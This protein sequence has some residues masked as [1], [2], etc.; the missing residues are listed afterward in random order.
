M[1]AALLTAVLVPVL[2]AC[3]D[4]ETTAGTDGVPRT[5][6]TITVDPGS[7]ADVTT[8]SLTCEPSGGNHP[9]PQ[10]AC[11][12]L[13]DRPT[14][15]L[16]PLRPVPATLA[17]TQV[18]GGDQTALIEGTFQG[19]PIRVELSRVN[20]CEIARWD[21]LVPLLSEPARRAG[22]V[23]RGRLDVGTADP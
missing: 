14:G 5:S 4:E 7:G 18:Y 9:D 10:A 1:V 20:G 22:G 3:A 19:Q 2:A 16:D 11:A 12:A 21:A 17:C 13:A 23:G 6:L 15:D 8:Y